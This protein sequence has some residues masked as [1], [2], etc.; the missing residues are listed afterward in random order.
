MKRAFIVP[1]GRLKKRIT[2][3]TKMIRIDRVGVYAAETAFFIILSA[4]PFLMLTVTVAGYIVDGNVDYYLSLIATYIPGVIGD[5]LE[6]GVLAIIKRPMSL[7][8]SAVATFWSAS[9][10]VRAARRGVRSVYGESADSF[11]RESLTGLIFTAVFIVLIIAILVFFVFGDA[12]VNLLAKL[13]PSIHGIVSMTVMLFPI[14]F[15]AILIFVFAFVLRAFTPAVAG[16]T[17]YRQH[18]PGAVL[19][20]VGWLAYSYIFSLFVAEFSS[21]PAIYGSLSA[22]MILMIWIYMIMYIFL[23]GAEFNK[24]L[25]SK[26]QKINKQ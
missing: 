12:L 17:S 6:I 16:M 9:K 25:Y 4:V 14:I 21:M 10:G 8:F 24:Y 13:I 2:D 19:A 15:T 11:I 22:I 3:V 7:S 5:Y 26:R 1:F 23:M 20:A 18:L